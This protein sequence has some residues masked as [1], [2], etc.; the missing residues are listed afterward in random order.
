MDWETFGFIF[1]FC[2]GHSTYRCLVS[3]LPI[4]I[5]V[6]PLVLTL[7]K[8]TK[9][10]PVFC[11]TISAAIDIVTPRRTLMV[12]LEDDKYSVDTLMILK[13]CGSRGSITHLRQ[14]DG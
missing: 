6:L 7:N 8:H 2:F 1:A 9:R 10:P 12:T 3:F 5:G 11:V 4:F 14:R 13:L